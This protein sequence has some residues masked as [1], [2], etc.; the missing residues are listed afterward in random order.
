MPTISIGDLTL[1]NKTVVPDVRMAYETWGELERYHD[2][3]TNAILINHAL[4]GDSHV[5]SSE[6]NT[7]EGW[8]QALVGPGKAIDTNRYCVVAINVFGGCSGSTGP[9]SP[10]P[11]GGIWGSRFP[12]ITVRDMVQAEA[13]VAEQLGIFS[14]AAVIGASAG[15]HRS[16]EWALCYP[17][18]V[19]RLVLVATAAATTADQSAWIHPQLGAIQADPNWCGGD[20]YDQGVSP[21]AGL[22]IARQIA[23]TTYRSAHELNSRFGRIAQ[24]AEEP[25]EG[26]RLAIQSYLDHHG[27]KLVNRFDAGSYV[28]L[29]HAMLTHDVGRNRGG[30][31]Y[32]LEHLAIP[33]LCVGVDSDRLFSAAEV[34]D[35]AATLPNGIYREIHSEH[36]HDGFLIEA[37]QLEDHVRDF[38]TMNVHCW[39]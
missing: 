31:G 13:K 12:L 1:E 36:G 7:E 10:H 18:R 11:D 9:S 4:T 26:G 3:R 20:Y 2:G 17:N 23:H 32:V 27:E 8:W 24:H 19:E 37:D 38:F 25:L 6:E 35:L 15:G 34:R 39:L 16:L 5:C 29:N 33:T 28:V 30:V 14:W 21:K 22:A